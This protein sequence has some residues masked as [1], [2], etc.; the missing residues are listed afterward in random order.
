MCIR[1]YIPRIDYKRINGIIIIIIII[2]SS[3]IIIIIIITNE[4][5]VIVVGLKSLENTMR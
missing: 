2:S 4:C 1:A 3:S 5:D